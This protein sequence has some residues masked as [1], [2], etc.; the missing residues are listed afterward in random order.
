MRTQRKL[1]TGKATVYTCELERCPVCDGIMEAVYTSGSK[2]VQTMNGVMR[3]AQRP[4]RCSNPGC[5]IRQV[6][7]YSAQWRQI[8][9]VSCTYGYDVIAQIGWQRQVDH[10]VFG[11]IHSVLRKRMQISETQV[12]VLYHERYLPL[13]ACHE[14]Q[15]WDRLQAVAQQGGLILGLDGL[16]P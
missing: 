3:I 10:Q 2:T 13:L 12:R 11:E 6:T 8:A 14:R 1:Y 15:Q 9:P 16:A 4:K 5:A 7:R